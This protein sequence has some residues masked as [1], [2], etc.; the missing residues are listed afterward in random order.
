MALWSRKGDKG[1]VVLPVEVLEDLVPKKEPEPREAWVA[2]WVVEFY[3]GE[4]VV[5]AAAWL[6]HPSDGTW[7]S[8]REPGFQLKDWRIDRGDSYVVAYF[9]RNAVRS[10]VSTNWRI[11]SRGS[12]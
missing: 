9:D 5:V 3:S 6:Q 8:E 11:E 2:D 1:S 4:P 12:W 7:N 10:I